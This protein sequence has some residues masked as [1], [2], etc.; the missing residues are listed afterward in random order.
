MDVVMYLTI[1]YKY[2][3]KGFNVAITSDA[4]NDA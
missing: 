4:V 3:R 1:K 2:V